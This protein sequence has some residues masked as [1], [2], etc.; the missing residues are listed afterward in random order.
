MVIIAPNFHVDENPLAMNSSTY[1]GMGHQT[2]CVDRLNFRSCKELG[3]ERLTKCFDSI[4]EQ[5]Q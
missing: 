1:L 2:F 4:E 3:A 5:D